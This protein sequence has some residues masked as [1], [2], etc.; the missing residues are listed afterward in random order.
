MS[1]ESTVLMRVDT[2]VMDPGS[3]APVLLLRGQDDPSLYLP[4]II[5]KPEAASIASVLAGVKLPRP[6][7]HDL[8]IRVMDSLQAELQE[9][10][11]VRLEGT[12]FFSELRVLD[13]SGEL[14]RIDARSSDSIAVALR[15]DVPIRVASEVLAAAGGVTE[16][17]SEDGAE[18]RTVEPQDDV[19]A[20]I[21]SDTSLEDLDGDVFGKYKM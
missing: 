18:P 3:K 19:P 7:T 4:I 1:A 10:V 12:T 21:G 17:E 20:I 14:R 11:I 9:V 16:S 15:C 2:I 6:L 13:V 5:G 8:L